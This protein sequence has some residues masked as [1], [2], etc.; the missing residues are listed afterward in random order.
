MTHFCDK[1]KH[2]HRVSTMTSK[3][4]AQT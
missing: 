2:T 1:W 3:Q 4:H